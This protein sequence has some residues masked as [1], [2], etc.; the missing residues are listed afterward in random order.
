MVPALLASDPA[1]AR[2][3]LRAA[4]PLVLLGRN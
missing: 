2:A 3:T 4:G 1:E